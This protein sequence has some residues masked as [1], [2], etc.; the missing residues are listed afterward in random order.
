M[1]ILA[2]EF[3]SAQRSVAVWKSAPGGPPAAAGRAGRIPQIYETIQTNEQGTKALEMIETV[4]AEG[5]IEREKIN[6]VAVGLGPGSY[7]GVRAAI[8]IAQGWQLARGVRL[9]G[10]SSMECLAAEAQAEKI[11]GRVNVVVDAQRNEIYFA[12]YE[13]S[14]GNRREIMP[15]SILSPATVQR[16][17]DANE[18]FIGPEATHWFPDGWRVFPRAATLAR[19]AA[20]RTDSAPGETL[21][22]IYLRET[23][24]AKLPTSKQVQP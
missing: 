10:V 14:S 24:F 9:L 3:S 23:R 21:E 6:V 7:T 8:S 13:I 22:P 2:L 18:I 5:G 19:L 15:L 11:S 17:T 4:L 20:A 1:M 16:W 12:A